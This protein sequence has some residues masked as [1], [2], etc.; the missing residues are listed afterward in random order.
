[1]Q[2]KVVLAAICAGLG[3]G[4]WTAQA[5]AQADARKLLAEKKYAEAGKTLEGEL[6]KGKPSPE[7]LSLGYLAALGEGR[8]VT[9][10]RRLAVLLSLKTEKDPE[11]LYL[12]GLSAERLGDTQTAAARF[13]QYARATAAKSDTLDHALSYL[14]L[15]GAYPAEYRQYVQHFGASEAAWTL[16]LVQLDLLC[17]AADAAHALEVAALLQQTFPAPERVSAV[18][19]RLQ[20]AADGYELGRDPRD[21]F[22]KPLLIM[23]A[24]VPANYDALSWMFQG[25]HSA[26]TP[27][28]RFGVALAVHGGANRPLRGKTPAKGSRKPLRDWL[29]ERLVDWHDIKDPEARLA[30][31]KEFLAQEPLFRDSSDRD[32]YLFFMSI[33]AGHAATFAGGNAAKPSGPVLLSPA[34]VQ[35]RFDQLKQKFADN[36]Q[37]VWPLLYGLQNGYFAG[38]ARAEFL[39]R[40]LAI[41]PPPLLRDLASLS[42]TATPGAL[43]DEFAKGRTYK[44]TLDAR[45][46]LLPL[47][48][49]SKETD[50]G[51][52]LLA[53]AREYM[54][55]YPGNFQWNTV[56]DALAGTPLLTPEQKI[57]LLKEQL[58]ASGASRPLAAVLKALATEKWAAGPEFQE[59]LTA[60]NK[61]QGSDLRARCHVA[62]CHTGE[63][64]E[65]QT[66]TRQFLQ[67]YKGQI[68]GGPEQATDAASLLTCQVFARA[69]E[70]AWDNGDQLG[71]MM[72]TWGARLGPGSAWQTAPRR[73]A[74][75]GRW[76]YLT[77]LL[78]RYLA[79]VQDGP[80]SP[81]SWEAF[82]QAPGSRD[83]TANPLSDYYARMGTALALRHVDRNAANW[84]NRPQ[85]LVEQVQKLLTVAKGELGGGRSVENIVWRLN[86]SASPQTRI[87]PAMTRTLLDNVLAEEARSGLYSPW[88]EVWCCQQQV[89]SGQDARPLVTSLL[90]DIAK[91][92]PRQQAEALLALVGGGVLPGEAPNGE[93]Q[94]GK[95]LHTLVRVLK[96]A[97]DKLPPVVLTR[98]EIPD[99]ALT[100]AEQLARQATDPAVRTEAEVL[101]RMLVCALADG[102][103]YRGHPGNLQFQG[104][105]GYLCRR[106]LTDGQPE[107]CLRLLVAGAALLHRS[108]DW[109]NHLKNVLPL[110]KAL[111]ERKANETAY[112]FIA[113][114]ERRGKAPENVLSQLAVLK[115]KAGADIKDLV[116]VDKNDPLYPLYLAAQALGV[117]NEERAWELAGPRLPLLRKEWMRL[118]A[119]FVAWAVEQM[120]KQKQLAPALEFAMTILVQEKNLEPETAA[121]VSLTRGDVYR[122]MGNLQAA[123]IEYDGLRNHP[124]YNRTPTGSRAIWRLID[125]QIATKDYTGATALL[126]RLADSDK[127]E[128]QADAFYYFAKMAHQEQQYKEAKD[129]LRRVKER[130]ATHV[131]AA[132]LEGEL[133]LVLPGGLQNSEVMVGNPRLALTVIPGRPLT[134]K[135]QDQNL[136]VARGGAAIPVVITSSQGKD[137]EHVKL[138]PSATSKNLFTGQIATAL[139]EIKPDNTVLE[140]RGDDVVSYEIEKDF[141]AANGLE[142]PAK[143]LEVRFDARLAASSGEILSEEEEEK[144]AMERQLSRAQAQDDNLR[145]YELQRDNRTV[146]PGSPLFVQVTDFARDL[147]SRPD[148]VTVALRT[149]SGDAIESFKLTETGTHTGVFRGAVPTGIPLPKV[150]TSDGADGKDPAALINNAR[151]EGWSSLPDGRRPKWIEADTMSSVLVKSCTLSVPD[152]AA[153]KRLRLLGMLAENFEELGAW[154]SSRRGEAEGGLTLDCALEQRGDSPEAMRRFLN[155]AGT[156]KR[157]E[158]TA[159]SREDS[160]RRG[161][162]GWVT[163]RLRGTFW[164]PEDRT[165]ELKFLQE[166]ARNDGWQHSYLFVDGQYV[167]GG[168]INSGTIELTR[169]LTLIK[170]AHRL[171]VLDR[172]NWRN[173]KTIVGYRQDD[174]TFAPLP[175]AWFATADHPGLAAFLKPKGEIQVGDGKI[176]AT[177]AE[178][179][180]LRRLRW[181]FEDFAGNSITVDK[182]G[183]VDAAGKTVL[184]T[185][186]D[187]SA[188]LANEVLEIAPGDHIAVSYK[189]DKGLRENTPFLEAVLNAS[190]QNGSI[191]LANETI[192]TRP[193]ST[194]RLYEYAPAKRCRPGDQLMIMVTD[195]DG[196]VSNERDTLPVRVSTASGE[197]LELKALETNPVQ[198]ADADS[199]RHTG[200]FMAVLRI[201]DQTKGDQLKVSP[202]D[203]VTAN[204]LDAENTDPGVPVDRSYSISEAGAGKPE[205]VV[206]RTSVKQ[207]RDTSEEAQAR[208]RRLKAKDAAQAVMY[209]DLTVATHPSYGNQP[210]PADGVASVAV[211]APLLFEL[212]YP[213]LALNA[214]SQMQVEAL[215]ESEEKAALA[216]GRQ[217]RTLQVPLAIESLQRLA[218]RKGYPVQVQSHIRR[219]APEMLR[220]GTFAGVVRLQV[221]S[222]GDPV[223]DLVLRS[224]TPFVAKDDPT[225]KESE[226]RVPTLIVAGSDQVTLRVRQGAQVLAETRVRLLSD[227]RLELLDAALAMQK[228]AVH[229]GERFYLRLTDPDQDRADGRDSVTVTAT[230]ASGASL[231]LA[232]TETL[233]HSGV[234][235]GSLAPEFAAPPPP[236][237]AGGKPA[238]A[239]APAAAPASGDTLRVGFGEEIAFAYTDARTLA[240][241][242]AQVLAKGRVYPGSDAQLACFSKQFKDPEMAVKTSFLMA[243]AL[244]EMAKEHRK[245][246]QADTAKEEIDRGKRILEEAM[247]DYPNTTL[248]AQG[249]FLLANLAQE[250]EGYQEAIGRYSRVINSWPDSEFAAR[251]QLK[252]A[253]CLEKL[254]QNDQACEE[255]VKVIYVY[256]DNANLVADATVRLG[257][258]Y[259][260]SESYKVAG[261]VFL[262]FRERNPT[263]L[264]AAKALF[265]AAQCQYKLKDYR[266]AAKMLTTLV[267][268]YNDQKDVREEAMYWLGDAYYNA[269]DMVKAYQA[270]K[271]LTWDYP[272][273]KWAK[274]ARGRLTEEVFAKIEEDGK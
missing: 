133:N 241:P 31:A 80:G 264:M 170:G 190:F 110:L 75:H 205:F 253:I 29:A 99:G 169:S 175:P 25:G 71:A 256:P 180:R 88:V 92:T 77:R 179:L 81:Q 150:T 43:L 152:A 126:E 219:T 213:R 215:A 69:L 251:A 168:V 146:R 47:L 270:F 243:E 58:A 94:P 238:P 124:L 21:R 106:A 55:A 123:R 111:D 17:T 266:E 242:A 11:L 96:P 5:D 57:A 229:L 240:G 261:Q 52:R 248:V 246:G 203:L 114:I 167:L 265:L 145:R 160:P 162:D 38:E 230:A 91:R 186:H 86:E 23:A 122:D 128:E 56:R 108:Q 51:P 93:L 100:G 192:A 166:P 13:A 196:D 206:Y 227:A 61:V 65:A 73:L 7:A 181:E 74:E 15:H 14:L 244:F 49:Q 260:K 156:A 195:Y 217:P 273:G 208:L 72:D 76:T 271:K 129:Y 35:Q 272:E 202:G 136:S 70:L 200:I 2:D 149:S 239:A 84:S 67:D 107:E 155:L 127:P 139:G 151:N 89:R 12:A 53:A 245:L 95:H 66:L 159:L 209:K 154:P 226:D 120:R 161:Q 262:R 178:P 142:Y 125:L 254:G 135:L 102:A 184:P 182:L 189:N 63:V 46:A 198:P 79:L 131:E 193:G 212:A 147:G 16:G 153:C 187:F 9:A 171:E 83:D 201:G 6:A 62:L 268:E 218:E 177:L 132:L 54:A 103:P 42:K 112:A 163:M 50:A 1:M 30:A 109:D 101:G 85:F 104:L 220:D 157:V 235:T 204:Y 119:Q 64:R 22:V 48:A 116:P 60:S 78:P 137:V 188:G 214:G 269:K 4:V 141:Q 117:G 33:V 222:P 234:F 45:A 113:A 28:E 236:V 10:E 185:A 27:E 249:E 207:V 134:L 158:K 130:V 140:L 138:L 223:N 40:H 173:G 231:Q 87:P 237:P 24:G 263:H 37:A 8:F 250:L 172:C 118:D 259:Y 183:L 82:S 176:T 32:D 232:L 216:E 174:G 41:L 97:L 68:P 18:H 34:D 194:E 19:R 224:E 115:A 225:R 221:G 90:A 274:I 228:N 44:D 20:A 39:R 247:R 267:D 257:N 121:R 255:Y 148:T 144:R 165:L 197:K 211:N 191:V 3:V 199:S 26:M 164:L 210:K 258:Y 59:L 233:P 36:P 98:L 105:S 143:N 252:K